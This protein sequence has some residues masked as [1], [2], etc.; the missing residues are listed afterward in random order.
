M[1]YLTDE[2]WE[3]VVTK[4]PMPSVD[5][6][7]TDE[8]GERVLLGRRENRP[9]KHTWFVPGSRLLKGERIVEAVERIAHEECGLEV[10]IEQ[11]LG[12]YEHIYESSD[13][14]PDVGKHYI[15]IAFHVTM[16]GGRVKADDQHGDLRWFHEIPKATH[17]YTQEYLT[18]AGVPE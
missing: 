1:S 14:D 15:P 17:H 4:M 12:W 7:I 9:A 6:V 5:L 10:A 16:T 3:T 13:V 8:A 11:P 2:E 18:D